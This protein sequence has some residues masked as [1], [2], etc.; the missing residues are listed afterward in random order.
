MSKREQLTH[1][2]RAAPHLL[3]R[4]L[5]ERLAWESIFWPQSRQ[6]K[7]SVSGAPRP[8]PVGPSFGSRFGD[9]RLVGS[10]SWYPGC[11]Y[12]R[13]LICCAKGPDPREDRGLILVCS[14]VALGF[15]SKGDCQCLHWNGSLRGSHLQQTVFLYIH[16]ITSFLGEPRIGGTQTHPA[17]MPPISTGTAMP[18]LD[19]IV[20]GASLPKILEDRIRLVKCSGQC[21][22]RIRECRMSPRQLA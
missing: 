5:R 12:L 20:D 3:H 6:R 15:P 14:S 11:R 2:W 7:T 22:R 9:E 19:R 16:W 18:Q 1:E 4:A 21:S 13:S 17:P 10:M 8:R